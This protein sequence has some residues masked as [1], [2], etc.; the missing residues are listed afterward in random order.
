MCQ[1]ESDELI[2][3]DTSQLG[4]DSQNGHLRHHMLS[5]VFFM[6]NSHECANKVKF[7]KEL[8]DCDSNRLKG[9]HC[10]VVFNELVMRS[11]HPWEAEQ[12]AKGWI[13][14]H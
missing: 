10:I 6:V 3:L 13:H 9:I 14:H 7:R 5:F 12:I 8:V 2:F 11:T 1:T 4:Y